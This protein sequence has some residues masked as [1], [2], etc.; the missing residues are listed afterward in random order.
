MGA[1]QAFPKNKVWK[2]WRPGS[3]GY[4]PGEIIDVNVEKSQNEAGQLWYTVRFDPDEDHPDGYV[5]KYQLDPDL[6]EWA[7]ENPDAGANETSP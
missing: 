3:Y 6:H 1:H 5:G 4:Y 7:W 2:K